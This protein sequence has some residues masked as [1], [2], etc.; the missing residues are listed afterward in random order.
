M[1]RNPSPADPSYRVANVVTTAAVSL[2]LMGC[3]DPNYIVTNPGQDRPQRYSNGGTSTVRQPVT[4]TDNQARA[5]Y[6]NNGYNFIDAKVL[7]NYWRSSTSQAKVRLGRKMLNFGPQDGRYHIGQA[8]S[9]AVQGDFWN[10]PVSFTDGNYSYNDAV[11]LGNYWGGGPSNAKMKLARNL[12]EG[13]D[14]WN[15]AA[16][17]A[18]R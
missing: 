11:L 3:I 5:K 14:S 16:L 8:R 2:T 15:R 12:I 18:A 4:F 13:K 1:N 9:R 10:W 17:N 7:A 6:F